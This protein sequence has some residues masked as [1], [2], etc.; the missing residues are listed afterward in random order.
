M[1]ALAA[2]VALALALSCASAA[3]ATPSAVDL[4]AVSLNPKEGA[5]IPTDLAVIDDDGRPTTLGSVTRGKPS[6]LMLADYNCHT[7]CG[8]ILLIAASAIRR[9]GLIAGKDFNLVVVG[10]DARDTADDAL[11]MK[12]ADFGDDTPLIGAHFV[13]ADSRSINRLAAAISYRFFYDADSGQFAHP[14][15]L[16]VL[17]PAGRV[18]TLLPGLA[19][20]RAGLRFAMVAAGRGAIASWID[21]IEV[22]CCGFAPAYG[23]YDALVRKTLIAA[24]AAMIVSIAAVVAISQIRRRRLLAEAD[25]VRS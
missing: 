25:R 16:L 8:P 6:L 20:T 13:R 14:T 22:I 24:A 12:R 1:R 9:S 10:L 19:L 17:T 7:I 5:S 2:V 23:T 18:S 4:A 15:D 11:R 21:R 3:R